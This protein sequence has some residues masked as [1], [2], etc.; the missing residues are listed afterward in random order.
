[1]RAQTYPSDITDSQ[2]ALLSEPHLPVYPGG[3][4]RKAD[5]RDVVN[6]TFYLLPA[7]CQWRYLPRDFPPRST[8]W[9]YFDQWRRN[10]TLGKIHDLPRT[11]VRTMEKPYSP[12]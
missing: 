11:R 2:W 8:A 1:M 7:G 4:P 10:R 3:R 5:L 12:R 9:C 6:A